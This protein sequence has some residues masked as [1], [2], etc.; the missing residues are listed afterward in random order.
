MLA[1]FPAVTVTVTNQNTDLV[2]TRSQD[3]ICYGGSV[4]LG[5]GNATTVWYT[6]GGAAE[7]GTGAFITVTPQ[8]LLIIM[9]KD[10][11]GMC[12]SGLSS[13]YVEVKPR[14][15]APHVEDM[16]FRRRRGYFKS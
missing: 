1:I 9:Q 5:G 2:L 3:T 7:I 12:P 14:I 10:T 15:P 16:V 8:F 6:D 13:I 4:D 11:A